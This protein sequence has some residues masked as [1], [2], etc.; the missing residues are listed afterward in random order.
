MKIH[1][2]TDRA[3]EQLVIQQASQFLP[4]GR[5]SLQAGPAAKNAARAEENAKLDEE[6]RLSDD[7]EGEEPAPKV[8]FAPQGALA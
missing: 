3:I 5:N 6:L 2:A 1:S 7:E 8:K 4:G